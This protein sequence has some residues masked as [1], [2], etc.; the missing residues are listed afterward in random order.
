M[1]W[2]HLRT[3]KLT[4]TKDATIHQVKM[5]VVFW[6]YRMV[7]ERESIQGLWSQA[8][9]VLKSGAI[10]FCFFFINTVTSLSFI[11]SSAKMRIP[12]LHRD[13]LQD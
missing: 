4:Q 1:Y 8:D 7:S 3:T 9:L 10:F 2:S 12:L 13:A 11:S 6:R 5:S